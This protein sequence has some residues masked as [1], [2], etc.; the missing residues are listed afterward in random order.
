MNYLSLSLKVNRKVFLVKC[1]K[2]KS[3]KAKHFNYLMKT[4][5]KH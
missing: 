3:L 1:E 4:S 2:K 5:N